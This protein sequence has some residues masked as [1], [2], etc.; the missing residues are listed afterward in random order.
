[1]KQ[2]IYEVHSD[3]DENNIKESFQGRGSKQQAI[4]YAKNNR[5][6]LTYVDK[7]IFNDIDETYEYEGC[8]WAYNWE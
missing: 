2:I 7:V 6:D 4:A 8:V 3:L 1:M 5:S